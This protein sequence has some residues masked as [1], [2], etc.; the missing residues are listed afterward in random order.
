MKGREEYVAGEASGFECCSRLVP[1]ELGTG[2][3]ERSEVFDYAV[4]AATHS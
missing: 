2:S 4:D 1:V 3:P